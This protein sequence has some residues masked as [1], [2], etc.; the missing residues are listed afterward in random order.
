MAGQSSK[1]RDLFTKYKIP[2]KE[3]AKDQILIET[4]KVTYIVD[5]M[6]FKNNPFVF[7]VFNKG[8]CKTTVESKDTFLRK[9]CKHFNLEFTHW[10][11]KK[12]HSETQYTKKVPEKIVIGGEYTTTWANPMAKWILTE[13]TDD[14]LVI[15]SS[16]KNKRKTLSKLS[17]LRIWVTK[18]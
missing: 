11:I 15:L 12:Q 4:E 16:P 14:D 1:N 8:A 9:L 13:I 5:L 3:S 6:P 2:F 10:D 17:D 7:K 18:H